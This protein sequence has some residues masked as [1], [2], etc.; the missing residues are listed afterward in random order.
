VYAT[1]IPADPDFNG[2]SSLDTITGSGGYY[3][4]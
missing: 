3:A 2:S 4:A 1:N